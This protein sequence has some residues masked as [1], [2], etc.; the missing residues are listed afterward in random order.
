[1]SKIICV[2]CGTAYPDSAT[3]CPI[4]GYVNSDDAIDSLPGSSVQNNSKS[5]TYVKGGRFSKTN[6]KKRNRASQTVEK[7]TSTAKA[8]ST[9]SDPKHNA[10]AKKKSNTGLI[11]TAIVLL[12]A[13]VAVV[14]YLAVKLFWPPLPEVQDPAVVPENTAAQTES[15]VITCQ[16][17]SLDVTDVVFEEIGGARMIYAATIPEDTTENIVFASSDES[18]ATVTQDGKVESV[19]TG[20]SIITVSCGEAQTSCVVICEFADPTEETTEATEET[21]ATNAEEFRLNREDI[22]LSFHG[23]KWQLYDGDLDPSEITW[24]TNNEN[25]ATIENGT[26]KAV[27]E[28]TT[29]VHGEYN[30]VKASC[31]IRCVFSSSD[32]QGVGGHGG[33]GADGEG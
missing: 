23:D 17:I 1:M 12:L 8:A 28:G 6:V 4:C 10:K 7:S 16:E 15:N 26:V 9:R 30:G 29:T 18:V 31:I 24:T 21:T 3:Q 20:T 19:G 14:I 2:V 13:I 5:Y 25:V 27:S 11:V 22:T 33:A 32:E